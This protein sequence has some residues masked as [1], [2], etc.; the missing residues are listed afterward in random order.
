MDKDIVVICFHS[1]PIPRFAVRARRENS[2]THPSIA[3]V[4]V[5]SVLKTRTMEMVELSVEAELC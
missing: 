4:I 2:A 3:P 1:S 5:M